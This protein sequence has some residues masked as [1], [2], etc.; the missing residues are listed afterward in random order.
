MIE[1]RYTKSQAG[2][3]NIFDL[4]H[5]NDY[6][7]MPLIEQRNEG[8]ELKFY[9]SLFQKFN[10]IDSNVNGIAYFWNTYFTCR[11]NDFVFKMIYDID[12]DIVS[13]AVD[14]EF[15]EQREIIAEAIKSLIEKEG[16]K[17]NMSAK[18]GIIDV[19]SFFS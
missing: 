17:I 18:Y 7:P 8:T 4:F 3:D 2:L 15:I 10:I 19:N 5:I 16:L 14:K 12:Y 11:Y 13:F 6:I 1:I 9:L